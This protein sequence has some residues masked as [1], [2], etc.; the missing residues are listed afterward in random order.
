MADD[1]TMYGRRR[2]YEWTTVLYMTC[3][4]KHDAGQVRAD[5]AIDLFLA[6]T[7]HRLTLG[8]RFMADTCEPRHRNAS[9]VTADRSTISLMPDRLQHYFAY[10]CPIAAVFHLCVAD[11][12]IVGI[13]FMYVGVWC[14]SRAVAISA[15]RRL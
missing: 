1:G 14:D 2:H 12:S 8:I 10:A 13:T 11:R 4:S 9:A 5:R 6:A 3:L 15:P 7:S